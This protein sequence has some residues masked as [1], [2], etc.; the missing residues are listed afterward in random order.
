MDNLEAIR[1]YVNAN[2]VVIGTTATNLITG[3]YGA[4]AWIEGA[5]ARI[6]RG[7]NQEDQASAQAEVIQGFQKIRLI[8]GFPADLPDPTIPGRTWLVSWATMDSRIERESTIT[9]M[10]TYAALV[11]AA[12]GFILREGQQHVLVR[13]EDISLDELDMDLTSITLKAAPVRLGRQHCAAWGR[14]M[15]WKSRVFYSISAPEQ[16]RITK[17][18]RKLASRPKPPEE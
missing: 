18:A 13:A 14:P 8:L 16:D 12:P 2:S 15:F 6:E 7:E 4:L 10:E 5:M 9:S 17:P 3:T 1:E 11:V